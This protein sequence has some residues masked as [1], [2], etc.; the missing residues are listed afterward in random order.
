MILSSW[1]LQNKNAWNLLE[2]Y[3]NFE[4]M[5]FIFGYQIKIYDHFELL[6]FKL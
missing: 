4:V 6:I 5:I 1:I 3:K 2:V